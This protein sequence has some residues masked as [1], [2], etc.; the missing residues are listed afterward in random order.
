MKLIT[1]YGENKVGNIGPGYRRVFVMDE[2][3]KWIRLFDPYANN[4]ARIRKFAYNDVYIR[5]EEIDIEYW[6]KKAGEKYE[7]NSNYRKIFAEYAT[8][9]E[10]S[11]KFIMK[12]TELL[13]EI[14]AEL[15]KLN[16]EKIDIPK[17]LTTFTIKDNSKELKEAK[18]VEMNF[19]EE[20]LTI[21]PKK[22]RGRP[23]G[24]KNKKG[25]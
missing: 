1:I 18:K 4:T 21:S 25:K 19:N 8:E 12:Q 3:T 14:L 24:S 13:E 17:K 7:Q 16:G 6:V 20:D 2:G 23:P 15:K 22:R 5:D 9:E 11:M 10:M